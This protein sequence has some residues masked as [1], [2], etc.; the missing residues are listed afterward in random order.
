MDN[1][2]S[3]QGYRFI[4]SYPSAV[5]SSSLSIMLDQF[6]HSSLNYYRHDGTGD[7][8]EHNTDPTSERGDG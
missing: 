7:P 1:A 8:S 6:V 5:F 2:S 4:Q 3:C